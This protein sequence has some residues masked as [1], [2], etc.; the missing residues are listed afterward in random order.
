MKNRNERQTKRKR[1]NEMH[2]RFQQISYPSGSNIPHN[3]Q[4][5]LS[6]QSNKFCKRDEIHSEM[7][8]GERLQLQHVSMCQHLQMSTKGPRDT[9]RVVISLSKKVRVKPKGLTCLFFYFFLTAYSAKY[10]SNQNCKQIWY[11]AK[12][13]T[14]KMLTN[15]DN[16]F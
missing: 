1:L 6:Q 7:A 16:V 14:T 10:T 13:R 15:K 9:E 4:P 2:V 8:E 3:S 5:N 12:N 11:L